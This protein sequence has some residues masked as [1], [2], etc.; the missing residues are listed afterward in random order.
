MR[1][2]EQLVGRLD[3]PFLSGYRML[4][5]MDCLTYRR[6]ANPFAFELCFDSSGRLIE[7][8]DRRTTDR[9]IASL[10]A[11]PARSTIRFDPAEIGRLLKRMQSS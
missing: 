2:I 1:R 5:T 7:A 6:G 11:D 9:H 10:R 3:S 8:I 4:P